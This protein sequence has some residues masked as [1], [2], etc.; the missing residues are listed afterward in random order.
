MR[1]RNLP[2]NTWMV[3]EEPGKYGTTIVSRHASQHEAEA[4][5]DRRNVGLPT[6]RYRACIV[7]EPIAQRMGGQQSPTTRL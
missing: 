2:L 1:S 3:I 6:A 4:E 5:C 7:L